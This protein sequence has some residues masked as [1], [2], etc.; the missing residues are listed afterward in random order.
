MAFT[1]VVSQLQLKE[2]VVAATEVVTAVVV[3]GATV[4]VV[5]TVVVVGA[6]VVVVTTV[7]VA[8]VSLV[9]TTVVAVPA[10]VV[11]PTVV[12][13]VPAAAVVVVHG[14][15]V[16]WLTTWSNAAKRSMLKSTARIVWAISSD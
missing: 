10:V 14:G 11:A 15:H 7:V 1:V 3:V 8:S 2:V 16:T 5:T 12:L 9:V 13:V 6:T 4:V